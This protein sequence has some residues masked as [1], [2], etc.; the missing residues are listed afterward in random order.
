MSPLRHLTIAAIIIL[1]VSY[2]ITPAVAAP[3][4]LPTTT[5]SFVHPLGS[6]LNDVIASPCSVSPSNE[7][8]ATTHASA[9]ANVTVPGTV[10]PAIL[11]HTV[12][13]VGVVSTSF[14]LHMELVFK[15]QNP[16]QFNQ[17]LAAISDPSSPEYRHFLN[18]TTLTPFVE[19]PIEKA[20][21]KGFLIA[22][23]FT[24][25]DGASPL[26][27]N[28]VGTTG[29]VQNAFQVHVNLYKTA[30]H[31]AFYSA[32][33]DPTLP[34]TIAN[35][36]EEITGLENYTTVRP[37]EAP[38]SLYYCP[39]GV[40]VGYNMT[41]LISSGFDGA[42]TTVAVV[43]EP[44][45]S[46]P[47]CKSGS[48][49]HTYDLQYH[50]P[51][52]NFQTLCGSGTTFGSCGS[53]ISYDPDWASE[54]AMDIEA[55]HSMAPGAKIVLV[56]GTGEDLMDGI[57][58]VAMNGLASVISN[59]WGYTGCSSSSCSDTQLSSSFVSGEDMR[60]SLAAG[61]G[62]TILFASGDQGWEPDGL[63]AGTEFPAS[64]SNVLAVGA[65][66]LV[67]NGCG[68]YTCTGYGSESGAS[69]SGGGYSGYFNETSWQTSTIGPTAST[70]GCSITTSP[71]HPSCRGVPDVSMLGYT[72]GFWVY[73]T[74]SDEC[75]TSLPEAG[76]FGCA[77]TSLSTPLWAGFLAVAV[78]LNAGGRFGNIDPLIYT[79]ASGSRYSSDFHDVTTGSNPGFPAKGG[80]YSAGPGWDPVT[81]WGTPI[82]TNLGND[83][84]TPN[85][86]LANSGEVD[87]YQGDSG[88]T[89]ISVNLTSGALRPTSLA[90]VGGLPAR[91]FCSFSP[92]TATPNYTST[93]TIDTEPSTPAGF[94]DV[95]V[96]G[97][98]GHETK[99][100]SFT[101]KVNPHQQSCAQTSLPGI[102]NCP[103]AFV[104]GWNL[105][106][107][108]ITPLGNSTF[109]NTVDGIFGS[110]LTYGFM[111]NVTSVYTYTAGA[112]QYCTVAKQGSGSYMRSRLP[113]SKPVVSKY[114]CNGTLK[115]MVD[116]KGYWV[117]AEVT[118]TLNNAN[119]LAPTWG[120]LV[121]SVI[122][123]S[124]PP[125]SYSLTVGWNLAGYK[126]EPDPTM[127][128][129]VSTYLSSING[130][131]NV[132]SVWIYDNPTGTWVQATG[133]T[134][135]APGEAMWI[136][137]T[138]HAG[139]TLRP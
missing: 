4:S 106:S 115:N 62:V 36:V 121:G 44:G 136:Y 3:N 127:S 31:P 92:S 42:G 50:L 60:L 27:L 66:N 8:Q 45:D 97:T 25:T 79:L 34:Q 10:V 84:G 55:V 113:I 95:V 75:A 69:I 91:A 22:N 124:S 137:V 109:P 65:T 56:Y 7:A 122:V 32:D 102:Y 49:L 13:M 30:N 1:V 41:S 129:T 46:N 73:S 81:G 125:P 53:S 139:A 123:P 67:L 133:A 71:Q 83:L 16:E 80:G 74:D 77:G 82:G 72:P 57:D 116:G 51:D 24:V 99:S 119:N 68:T 28:L 61:M 126:P 63:T 58:Y 105:V 135:I 19:T 86:T 114:I 70:M 5:E 38:C 9:I 85:F 131:Y 134:M 107:L 103:L 88:S 104:Q 64:D 2:V 117:Y 11:K 138:S 118:F 120:G 14:V 111:G 23:G 93:L 101:L 18:A 26:V 110:N 76:W 132:N 94:Y 15:I 20:S 128:E 29:L 130:V 87:A 90:C 89:R 12:P 33:T 17:C 6:N 43:D 59:S 48:A 35:L 54:A 98:A 100:T 96:N 52:P 37:A 21:V 78:Q 112:W 108:P 39:Q 47:C 40:E